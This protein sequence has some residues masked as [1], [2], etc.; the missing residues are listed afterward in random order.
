MT[1]KIVRYCKQLIY[2]RVAEYFLNYGGVCQIPDGCLGIE[3]PEMAT[4]GG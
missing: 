2:S 4:R 1:F 3:G